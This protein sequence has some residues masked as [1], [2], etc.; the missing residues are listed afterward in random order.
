MKPGIKSS[1]FIL[2]LVVVLGALGIVAV[3]L[4]KGIAKTS[5]VAAMLGGIISAV[6]AAIGYTRERT[7]IKT[8]TVAD[9]DPPST[10]TE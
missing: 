10:E 6:L 8:A 7:K 2:T 3:L 9:P 5:D 4:L 1:E